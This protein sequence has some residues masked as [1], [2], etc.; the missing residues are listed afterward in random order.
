MA[1]YSPEVDFGAAGPQRHR[2]GA[3]RFYDP[4]GRGHR[5]WS[6]R[7]TGIFAGSWLDVPPRT[8]TMVVFEGHVPHDSVR[9]EGVR[10]VCPPT[11]AKILRGSMRC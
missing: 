1:T 6:N 3:L 10:R 8:G 11:M 4:A 2:E 5:L 9:F 7:N